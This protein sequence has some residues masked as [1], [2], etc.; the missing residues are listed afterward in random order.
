MKTARLSES[1]DC[2]APDGSEIRF[3]SAS[4]RGST[5]HCT[6]PPGKTSLA[7]AHHS[8]EEIWYFLEGRGQVWRKLGEKEE[9]VDASPG[10]SL[11][12]PAGTHFQF[13]NSGDAPLRFVLTTMPPWPG[14]SEAYRV[15]GHWPVEE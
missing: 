11:T 7:V 6:L 9:V 12:I 1:Y 15:P 13:R 2:L 14:D 5:V 10:V 4:E 8:V 3:L